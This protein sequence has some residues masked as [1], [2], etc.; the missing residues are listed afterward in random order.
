MARPRR[1]DQLRD[2]DALPDCLDQI[3]HV[4]DVRDTR[5]RLPSSAMI[6]GASELFAVLGDPTRL[7]LVGALAIRELCV[8]D[9]AAALGLSQSAVSHQLRLLRQL[10]IVRFRR[11]GRLI[12]YALDD[13]HVATLFDQ[14][15]EHVQHRMKEP[16]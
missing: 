14:A 7:R 4:S 13:E 10:G 2:P 12:Y 6:A 11:D 1:A 5:K 15:L 9:L 3:V 16:V 8:C